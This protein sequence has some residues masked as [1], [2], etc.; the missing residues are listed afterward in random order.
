MWPLPSYGGHAPR[1]LAL[2][3]GKLG[4]FQ[5]ALLGNIRP[6]LTDGRSFGGLTACLDIFGTSPPDLS[7][8][9]RGA[10][11]PAASHLSAEADHSASARGFHL[12]DRG[13]R[14][15]P[16]SFKETAS[17]EFT[18]FG[19][20]MLITCADYPDS[21]IGCRAVEFDVRHMQRMSR[22]NEPLSSQHHR[23]PFR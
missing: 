18:S 16:I 6:A 13:L 3:P 10:G 23:P 19:R 22:I 20:I 5:T 2:K 7:Q 1:S 21:L 12:K 15:A 11:L 8:D 17:Y 14:G 9:P 4:N